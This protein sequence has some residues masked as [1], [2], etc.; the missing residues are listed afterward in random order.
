MIFGSLKKKKKKEK[1]SGCLKYSLLKQELSVQ[2]S[3]SI[4][5]AAFKYE[6]EYLGAT[7]A[8]WFCKEVQ[9]IQECRGKMTCSVFKNHDF[10]LVS[11]ACW[12]LF[13]LCSI[14]TETHRQI[15][16]SLDARITAED[17]IT[18]GHVQQDNTVSVCFGLKDSQ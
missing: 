7:C 11:R 2:R 5:K 12:L 16:T 3:K 9:Q 1:A 8:V 4:C 10:P 15:P 13:L 17:P 18:Q 6:A 14:S